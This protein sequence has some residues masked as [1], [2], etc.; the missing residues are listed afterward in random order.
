MPWSPVKDLSNSTHKWAMQFV[1]TRP[2]VALVV[3]F[4]E[5]WGIEIKVTLLFPNFITDI[6]QMNES[7]KYFPRGPHVLQ[8]WT[9]RVKTVLFCISGGKVLPD[10]AIFQ[11]SESYA[12]FDV[13]A[14]YMKITRGTNLMHKFKI[15]SKFV[16]HVGTSLHFYAWLYPSVSNTLVHKPN[17]ICHLI[18]CPVFLAAL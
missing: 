8:P 11:I 1:M 3:T 13:C 9:S 2:R 6:I 10:V 15:I 17:P 18:F 7:S 14:S 5:K 12:W 4:I 16:H